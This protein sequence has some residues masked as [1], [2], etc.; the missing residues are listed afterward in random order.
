[1]PELPILLLLN[2]ALNGIALSMILFLLAAGFE[3]MFGVMRIINMAHGSY[4]MVGA[5]VG[6]FVAKHTGFFGLGVLAGAVSVGVLG[7]IMDRFFLRYLQEHLQQVFL[8][9]GVVFILSDIT[10]MI[11][12][13]D[14]LGIS[15]PALLAGSLKILGKSFPIYRLALIPIGL[16]V[17]LGLWLFQAKTRL[18]AIVRAGVDDKE[19]VGVIGINIKLLSTMVFGGGA[20]L[21][22]FGGMMA[23]PIIGVVPGLDWEILTLAMVVVVVGGL[24][25][26]PGALVG[27]LLIGLA[28]TFGK[29]L[30]PEIAIVLTF[31]ILAI[32]LIIKPS[33]IFGGG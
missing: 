10:R 22:G 19:M 13:G 20:L 17:A 26:L 15:T 23:S 4:F 9:F 8:T 5:Y 16:L 29:F 27:S 6:I 18:G 25:S 24:G 33:G 30:L 1:M 2:I 14:P 11:W 3:L 21:A 31:F 7:L 28:D 12:G 32:V